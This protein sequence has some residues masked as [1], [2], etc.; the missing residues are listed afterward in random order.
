MADDGGELL[1]FSSNYE[2]I[3]VEILSWLP[4]ISLLRFCCVCKSWRALISTSDFITKHL[5]RTNYNDNNKNILIIFER[6]FRLSRHFCDP[7]SRFPQI[8]D[9]LSLKK[10]NVVSSV[11]ASES[12]AA[13]RRDLEDEFPDDTSLKDSTLVG[14]CNGLICLLLEPPRDD[15]SHSYRKRYENKRLLLWN[16]STRTARKLPDID[17]LP[18]SPS[19]YGFGYD[20]TTQDYKVLL[21]GFD[22]PAERKLVAIFALKTGS[23]KIVSESYL[24]VSDINMRG[25]FLN[26]ALHWTDMNSTNTG[27]TIRIKFVPIWF[28]LEFLGSSNP[29][30]PEKLGFSEPDTR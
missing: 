30:F 15:W 21:G 7:P 19:F 1:I 12:A 6:P 3:I 11:S 25:C 20:S 17:F 5:G 14:S 28:R 8:V 26:G 18:S 24:Q 16:P 23:W 22:Y 4:V 2:D 13:I 9:Y 27:T 10:K 29:T